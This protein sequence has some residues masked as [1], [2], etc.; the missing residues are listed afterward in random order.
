MTYKRVQLTT[1]ILSSTI[2][3]LFLQANELFT[4]DDHIGMLLFPIVLFS[5]SGSDKQTNPSIAHN[6]LKFMHLLERY[7]LQRFDGNHVSAAKR[8]GIANEII[9]FIKY[10]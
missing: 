6:E 8:L 3:D 4:D 10:H 1:K 7:F 2:F 5:S 9:F